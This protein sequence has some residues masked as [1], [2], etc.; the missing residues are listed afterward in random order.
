M[1][2][3]KKNIKIHI[4]KICNEDTCNKKEDNKSKH[5]LDELLKLYS[6][7][8][9]NQEVILQKMENMENKMFIFNENQ[10]TILKKIKYIDDN[11]LNINGNNK[12]VHKKK[13]EIL[14]LIE[15]KKEN[16]SMNHD[17]V[18]NALKYRDYRSVLDIF[19]LYYKKVH[20]DNDINDTNNTYVYP[21]KV[22][23]ERSFEYFNDNKWI[24]DLYGYYITDIICKNIEVLF[25]EHN[26]INDN[27]DEFLLNEDFIKKLSNKKYKKEIF[28]HIIVEVKN[29]QK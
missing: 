15:I 5:I 3:K 20:L 6:K 1:E 19:K 2:V 16:I 17:I 8:H 7:I 14:D 18:L 22:I 13:D 28:R 10:K 12:I 4:K 24:S 26:I 21:I 25:I 9:E 27:I 11:I 29:Y 23:S